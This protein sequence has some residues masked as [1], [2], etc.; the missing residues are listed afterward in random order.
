VV[1]MNAHLAIMASIKTVLGK[2]PASHAQMAPT[3]ITKAP[4]T[5]AC[6]WMN[7]GHRSLVS[8]TLPL[9]Q[10]ASSSK[11]T[12]TGLLQIKGLVVRMAQQLSLVEPKMK[13]AAE[14]N[15]RLVLFR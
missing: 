6:A 9:Y 4:T 11:Q 2:H 8:I 14:P 7:A 5:S 10:F 12:R 15:V 13:Q 3:L 1:V